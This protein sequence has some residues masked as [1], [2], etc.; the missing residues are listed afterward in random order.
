VKHKWTWFVL[1]LVLVL[2]VVV[3]GCGKSQAGIPLGRLKVKCPI[4]AGKSLVEK[5]VEQLEES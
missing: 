3:Y 1:L 2:P 5:F 4:P